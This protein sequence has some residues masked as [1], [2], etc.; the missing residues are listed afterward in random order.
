MTNAQDK[1]EI[2]N[3]QE[4]GHQIDSS[5]FSPDSSESQEDEYSVES[6]RN[7]PH[8]DNQKQEIDRMN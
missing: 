1:V 7:I 3:L 2:T 8:T 4:N 6:I 5:L